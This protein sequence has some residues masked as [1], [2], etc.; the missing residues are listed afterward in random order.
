MEYKSS[1]IENVPSFVVNRLPWYLRC[2]I[3]NPLLL[4]FMVLIKLQNFFESVFDEKLQVSFPA[5][6]LCFDY[7][8][9]RLI[10]FQQKDVCCWIFNKISDFF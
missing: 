4:A 6:L 10:N 9:T 1:S 5:L 3:C 2:C 8:P 7:G